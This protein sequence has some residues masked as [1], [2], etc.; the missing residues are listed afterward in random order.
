MSAIPNPQIITESLH[1]RLASKIGDYIRIKERKTGEERLVLAM[2]LARKN[3]QSFIGVRFGMNPNLYW[4]NMSH[5]WA[6]VEQED[7]YAA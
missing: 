5:K 7:Q 1:S 2:E 6:L 3:N 4:Y